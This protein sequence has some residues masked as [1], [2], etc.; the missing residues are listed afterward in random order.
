MKSGRIS[1]NQNCSCWRYWCSPCLKSS[2]WTVTLQIPH[3]ASTSP[4]PSWPHCGGVLPLVSHRMLYK[5]TFCLLM[6]QDLQGVVLWTLH[7]THFWVSDSPHFTTAS[8]H[9]LFQWFYLTLTG[10]VYN[11]FL[12]SVIL[13]LLE[14]VPLHQ[15]HMW[16]MHDGTPPHLHCFVGTWPRT[17]NRV[18]RPSQQTCA[19]L[20][21]FSVGHLKALV[22]SSLI[23]DL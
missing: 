23:S 17:V 19:I 22:Y 2:S 8:R 12:L 7:T 11:W 10:A 4:R 13:V 15:E 6:R 1:Y 14:H 16:F 9:Q 21:I 3:L 18:W 5:H 20:W